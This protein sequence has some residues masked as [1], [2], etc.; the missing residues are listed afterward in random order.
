MNQN[1]E[2]AQLLINQNRYEQAEGFLGLALADDP[3]DSD[4]HALMAICMIRDRDRL[5]EATR[6]AEAA[7]H[8]DPENPFA[9]YAHCLVMQR[10]K[11]TEQAMTS[12]DRAIE[13]NPVSAPFHGIRA[14]LFAESNRWQQCLE[15]AEI[16]LEYDAE[17]EQCAALRSHA[18]ER[19]GRV[20]EAL[21]EAE[22]ATRQDP[23]SPYAHANRGWALLNKGDYR[24]AQ[25]AFRE[26]LRLDPGNEFARQ[27]M[28]SALN[29]NN[30][31]FRNFYRFMI[32]MSRLDS[33]V[34]WGL[35]IGL[36]LGIRFLNSAVRDHEWLQP[37]VLPISICYLMFVMMSWIALPLFNAFLR[38]H[39]FGRHLLSTKEKWASNSI[40]L[41]LG[42]GVAGGLVCGYRGSWI[43]SLLAVVF[44][45]YLTIPLSVPFNT[46][47]RWATIVASIIAAGFS[48]LFLAIVAMLMVDLGSVLFVQI[49]QF[50]ILIYCFAGNYLISAQDRV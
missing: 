22:R 25:L 11:Q 43:G 28:I 7:I 34:Q 47:A 44:A 46:S 42:I 6:E 18:L 39:P 41:A 1:I 30:F 49:Y 23:D 8:S 38:F 10:R 16:G 31:I 14:G 5:L 19:L 35:I 17:N 48:L 36:W 2:R 40:A 26:A 15:S 4:A 29:S 12:I 50:G 32:A 24:E 9:Y 33:R 45:I 37:W 3:Q 27:G 20:N 13:L 21:A